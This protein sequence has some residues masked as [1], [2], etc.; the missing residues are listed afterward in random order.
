VFEK[1]VDQTGKI[2]ADARRPRSG[3]S[4]TRRPV[5]DIEEIP[6]T[7]PNEAL[8]TLEGRDDASSQDKNNKSLKTIFSTIWPNLGWP[9]RINLILG[10]VGASVHAIAT[11]VFSYILSKLLE[12]YSIPGGDQQKSLIYAMAILGVAFVDSIG[13]YVFRLLLEHI[14]QSWIDS[15]RTNAYKQ[16]LDQSRD[17]FEREENG[18]SRLTES[19]DRNAEEMRN[20]LGRFAAMSYVAALMTLVSILWALAAQ[21]KTTLIA[22]AVVPYVF[23]VTR[24]FASV[25]EKWEGRSNDASETASAIFTE[26]FTNIKTVRALTLEP[27]FLEK[28]TVATNLTLR[29]GFQRSIYAGFFFGLSDS[30][31]NFATAMIFYVGAKLVTQGAP[32]NDVILVFTMLIFAI[33]NVSSMLE[34]IPQIGSSKDTASRLLRLAQLPKTSHEH[35]GDTHIT[36][37]GDIVFDHLRFCYPSRPEQTIFRDLNLRLTPGTTTAIVGGSGSGKSTIANLLLDLYNTATVPGAQPGDLTFGGRDVKQISTTCL[38]SL[39]TPV[40]QTPTLFAATVSENIAYGLPRHHPLHHPDHISAAARQAGIHDFIVSLP[41]GYRTPI[42]DGGIGLSGG[43]AQRIAIARALVRRP[44]VLILDEATSALDVSSANLIRATIQ[45]LVDDRSR[46]M[47]IV[48]I[49]HHRDMME[50]AERVVVLDSGRVAE[51]GPFDELMARDGA[52]KNLL[53][54]GEWAGETKRVKRSSR[55]KAAPMLRSVDWKP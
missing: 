15:I 37:V 30:A 48:I 7:G 47:T 13:T 36:A 28:Y 54:G 41:Q 40:S 8:A 31:G 2:A 24:I 25:S 50:I 11:P 49:T 6:L 46:A 44:S 35:L 27:H 10:F 17:F 51:E 39:I 23:G 53:S 42:G 32:V 18:V 45:H 5:E 12:T 4:R 43:Q 52:L 38:R 19:L 33:T 20:L 3:I 55:V 29:V 21:W 14:G 9:D 22:L 34:F 26:T 16:I 1:L